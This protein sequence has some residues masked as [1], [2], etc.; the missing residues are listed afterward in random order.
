MI[1]KTIMELEKD[2][3]YY[4]T[5]YTP[6]LKIKFIGKVETTNQF[7]FELLPIKND[8][9]II[10]LNE[11]CNI[12]TEIKNNI[13]YFYFSYFDLFQWLEY[14]IEHKLDILINQK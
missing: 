14:T 3:I 1:N 5:G 11:K 6:Y 4:H 8:I 10:N 12:I 2:Q 13:E 7:I 9:Y